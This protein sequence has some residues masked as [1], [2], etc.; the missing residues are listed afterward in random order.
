MLNKVSRLIN[1][2]IHLKEILTGSVVTFILKITG[3]LLG[4]IVILIISKKYGAEGV[5][6]YSL[7]LS[8]MTFF[9]MISTLGMNISILR[10]VGQ[11]NRGNERYKL[12]L[13]YR[14]ALQFVLPL[15]IFFGIF[16]YMLADFLSENIFHNSEYK[17]ALKFIAFILPFLTL[18]NISVEFI[19]GLKELKISEFLRSVGRPIVNILLLSTAGLYIVNK[20]FPVYTLGVGIVISSMFSYFFIQRKI[21]YLKKNKKNDNIFSQKEFFITSFPM[22]ISAVASFMMG[23]ISLVMLEIFSSTKDVG[24]YSV[25]FKLATLISLVLVVVNTIS[26]PKFS[27]LYWQEKYDELQKIITQST[28]LIFFSSVI[29]ALILIVFRKSILAL[30]GDE[31]IVGSYPLIVL[32][33]AQL[34]NSVTGSVSILLNMS[35][36]QKVLRNILLVTTVLSIVSSYFLVVNYGVDGAA[37][38]VVFNMALLNIVAAIYVKQ[39]L[40][41]VTYFSPFALKYKKR[42]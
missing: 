34:I 23:N 40:G 28:L 17:P 41:F 35:G 1:K 42:S 32:I 19:R 31:F 6:V 10:F 33:I 24:I 9:A 18:L 26:A 16:L 27:E 12:K 2:D 29:I 38:S 7:V 21:K 37:Y 20:I 30:F 14:Y 11:F 5:G 13:V 3:M 36:N 39:K 25:V 8:L 4:Y 15:S 22:M